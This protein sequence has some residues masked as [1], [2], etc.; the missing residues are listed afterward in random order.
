MITSAFTVIQA[1][2][3]TFESDTMA[4]LNTDIPC[5]DPFGCDSARDRRD[6]ADT[7]GGPIVWCS[8][9]LVGHILDADPA[10]IKSGAY[11]A[12]AFPR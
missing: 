4:E 3:T 5:F 6:V 7:Q 8:I 2:L 10:A 1:G 11:F 9:T 12:V